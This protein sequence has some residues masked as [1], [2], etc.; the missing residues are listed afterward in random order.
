M[1]DIKP[2]NV[3]NGL[4]A[5]CVIA[6]HLDQLTPYIFAFQKT[7]DPEVKL[8]L[9]AKALTEVVDKEIE[10]VVAF[11]AYA[12]DIST[13]EA[14]ELDFQYVLEALP[15]IFRT[16]NFETLMTAAIHFGLVEQKQG[17]KLWF[18]RR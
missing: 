7:K 1:L 15:I 16:N 18:L 12:L 14:G 17:I 6:R 11:M 4:K 2:M 5:I 10:S 8:G 9:V 13:E 3:R